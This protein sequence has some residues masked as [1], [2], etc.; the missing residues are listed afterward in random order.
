MAIEL[1]S[2]IFVDDAGDV[3]VELFSGQVFTFPRE[4]NWTLYSLTAEHKAEVV[5]KVL[6]QV[7]L[8]GLRTA[9]LVAVMKGRENKDD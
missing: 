9:G 7:T 8:D 3:E 6:N 1:R 5:S 4:E 2:Q